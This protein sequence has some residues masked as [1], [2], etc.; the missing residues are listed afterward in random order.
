MFEIPASIA[1][2]AEI[3]LLVAIYLSINLAIRRRREVAISVDELQFEESA[4][5][6][7]EFV[8]AKSKGIWQRFG[9]LLKP[10]AD[11]DEY[12]IIVE[13]LV[14][15]GRRSPGDLNEFFAKRAKVLSL[16]VGLCVLIVL[17][18]GVN[19]IFLCAP[20]LGGA[21]L[22]PKFLLNT[23]A[24]ARQHAI[25]DSVPAAL[26]LLEACIEAGLGLEQAVARVAAELGGSEPE[27]A[28]ELGLVVAELRAGMSLGGA[29]RK[30][31]DRV[32]ADEL[33]T[34]C[35]VVIQASTLGAP[36]SKTLKDYSQNA[37]KRRS[38]TLEEKAGRITAALTLPLTICLLPS[39]ILVVLGPA[40]VM[41][42]EGF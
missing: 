3:A 17:L 41:V 21:F 16:G 27:I 19:G 8:E 36:L 35:S 37:R 33:R 2:V 25:E 4:N 32:G 24:T 6:R 5:A 29:F 39:A 10:S 22:G 13:M 7:F 28:D 26:D 1:I 9:Q 14:K 38:L 20:V 11:S 42:M 34:L 31:S 30:L 23:Q 40:V 15:A 18:V 12:G